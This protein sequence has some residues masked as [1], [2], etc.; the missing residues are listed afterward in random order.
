MPPKDDPETAKVRKELD[1][2]IS[3][4]RASFE[5]FIFLQKKFC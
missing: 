2:L 3:K 4:I 1:D 5:L